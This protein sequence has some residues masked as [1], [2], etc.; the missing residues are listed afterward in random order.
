MSSRFKVV[1][2]A[3]PGLVTLERKPIG[4]T[5][6]YLERMFCLSELEAVLH[7]AGIQQINHTLTAKRGTVRGLH[8]QHPPHA[9]IKLVSCLVGEVYDV[10]VDLRK[11]SPTFLQWHAEI[12]TPHNHKTLVIPQG[13]A[14]GFQTLSDGCEM[15]YYHTAAY[16]AEA[17]GG[18]NPF[19]AELN[20]DWPTE[21][22]EISDRDRS[23][24]CIAKEDVGLSI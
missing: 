10:A 11:E 8:F 5:R 13:F 21:L 4:D 15:L 24:P 22:T 20:I 14:H 17:E 19:D 2:T 7:G 1:P 6:G 3:L 16:V 9:E 18:L 12:L 23:H